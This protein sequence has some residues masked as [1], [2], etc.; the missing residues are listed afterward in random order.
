MGHRIFFEQYLPQPWI[1]KS[2]LPFIQDALD[3]CNLVHSHR[4]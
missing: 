4:D 2:E 3:Q 1:E